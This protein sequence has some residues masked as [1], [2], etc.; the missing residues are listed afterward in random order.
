M[1]SMEAAKKEWHPEFTP[2]FTPEE[3]LKMG[4]SD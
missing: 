4:V 2:S 3:M 1:I